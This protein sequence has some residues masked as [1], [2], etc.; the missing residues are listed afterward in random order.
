[1]N[2]LEIRDKLRHFFAVNQI[3][4]KEFKHLIGTI[5][6]FISIG[7]LHRLLIEKIHIKKY[8]TYEIFYYMFLSILGILFYLKIV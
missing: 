4:I 8:R 6:L 1:M 2:T 5:M 3:N 7:G